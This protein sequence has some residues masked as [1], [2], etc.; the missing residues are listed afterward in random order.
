MSAAAD[1][2][3]NTSAFV[4]T[5]TVSVG[6]RLLQLPEELL[7]FDSVYKADG[8]ISRFKWKIE[9]YNQ[10]FEAYVKNV[11]PDTYVFPI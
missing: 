2:T 11:F 3:T 6:E 5:E 9:G 10:S 4:S 8:K 7:F 1:T